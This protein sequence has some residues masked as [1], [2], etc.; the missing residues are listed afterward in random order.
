V[1][2]SAPLSP[3]EYGKLSSA[4][5]AEFICYVPKLL[6]LI[7]SL[8]T[9]MAKVSASRFDE[10]LPSTYG[11]YCH[12]YEES[13]IRH[14]SIVVVVMNRHLDLRDIAKAQDPQEAIL[15][16]LR[17]MNE[18]DD[19]RPL[20]E[21]VDESM[22]MALIYSIGQ[23]VTSMATCGRS[24]S[25]LLHDARER[26]DLDA[27]FKAIRMDR[28]VIG[29]PTAMQLIAR[30]QLRNNKAFFTRLRSALAGP[31]KK[32]W[33]GLHPMRYA[34]I[35]LNE[36]GIHDLSDAQLETLMVDTLKAYPKSPSAR[37]NL[38]AQYRNFRKLSTI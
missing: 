2:R 34:F 21:G 6:E 15:D 27:L 14:L 30:A 9:H 17:N 19:D 28:A 37:K 11:D 25:G 35:L 22:A 29:C 8:S 7:R 1:I 16:I 36:M 18:P 33:E 3:K 10:L 24:I 23:T 20:F 4:Q 5:F 13:F 31:G 12:V 32:Q 38:R 26:G